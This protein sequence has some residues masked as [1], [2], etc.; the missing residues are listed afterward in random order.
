MLYSPRMIQ[1]GTSGFDYLDWRG[2]FYP[3]KLPRKQWLSYYSNYF[4]ALELNFSY[5]QM[6]QEAQLAS[7]VERSAGKVVFA[8]K[9]HRSM[10]HDRTASPDELA[11][12]VRALRPLKEANVL[13]AVLAQFP[14]S[15]KQCEENRVYLK[16]LSEQLGRPLVVELR[17]SDWA[18]DP[19]LKWLERLGIGYA[20]VDEPQIRGLM[21]P[22]AA[23]PAKPAYVR[24]HGRNADKW[25]QHDSPE[26]RYDYRYSVAEL[27][28]W[29][30]RI[31]D[32]DKKAGQ[33]LVFFNNH[34][35]SKA[36]ESAKTM[37][38]LLK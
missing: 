37:E 18:S 15:F 8:I 20:C 23:A 4:S 32:L 30:T 21:P 26:E 25:Y 5:Y 35:Q 24:F 33:V 6:P 10:T 22:I 28:E 11:A 2:I 14:Y 31:S 7:M 9:A 13:G 1:I 16:E 12:F 36:V 27:S 19:I 17:R 34:F 29:V 3:E 38:R